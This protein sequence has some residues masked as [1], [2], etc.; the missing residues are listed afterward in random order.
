MLVLTITTLL[1]VFGG[2]GSAALTVFGFL[3]RAGDTIDD[4]VE[5]EA[6]REEM[7]AITE[8]MQEDTTR[9]VRGIESHRRAVLALDL[10]ADSTRAQYRDTFR[11]VDADWNAVE[12]ALVDGLLELKG[13]FSHDEWVNFR[14]QVVGDVE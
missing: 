10:N 12:E 7:L 11:R 3:E 6:L 14:E 1:L 2:G 9:F 4:R 5:D 8:R 13:K